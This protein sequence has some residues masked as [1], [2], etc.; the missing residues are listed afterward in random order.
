MDFS[1]GPAGYS[2]VSSYLIVDEARDTIDLL[3]AVFHAVEFRHVELGNGKLRHAELRVDDTTIM[4]A[5]TPESSPSVPAHVHVSVSDVDATSQ[6]TLQAGAPAHAPH[7]PGSRAKVSASRRLISSGIMLSCL[8]G[9]N[10]QAGA[11][12]V[13]PY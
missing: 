3:S 7:T 6:R 9:G 13:G 5:D 11:K 1:C 10:R 12:R 4:L 8:R 2:S